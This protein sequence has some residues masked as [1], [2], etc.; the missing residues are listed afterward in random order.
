[1]AF[2]QGWSLRHA[3]TLVLSN[4]RTATGS[5]S[6]VW[7][8]GLPL[9]T[10]FQPDSPEGTLHVSDTV[11][12]SRQTSQ[13]LQAAQRSARRAR[14]LRVAGD[15][16]RGGGKWEFEA[17]K[18][19]ASVCSQGFCC[20][21]SGITGHATGYS[22]GA[23]DGYDA[24]DGESWGAQVCAVLLCDDPGQGCLT[25]RQGVS[26]EGGLRGVVV[27]AS[28]LDNDGMIVF[29]EV[30][31]LI[32]NLGIRPPPLCQVIVAPSTGEGEHMLAPASDPST[33]PDGG[34]D[35]KQAPKSPTHETQ[36]PALSQHS[37]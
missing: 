13:P 19:G 22:I 28:K 9:A 35:Y 14:L 8:E 16:V 7:S 24:N 21:T 4:L 31:A 30:G 2:A 33:N 29:P 20:T 26:A 1:M 6:G 36:L 12:G 32:S 10:T 37:S 5:G 3:S 18:E 17:L 15:G 34:F 11:S 25:Y 23:L 27:N